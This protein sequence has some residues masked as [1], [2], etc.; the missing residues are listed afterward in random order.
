MTATLTPSPIEGRPV[1]GSEL[2]PNG[3]PA[4]YIIFS[5]QGR[6][7]AYCW[8]IEYAGIGV[9]GNTQRECLETWLEEY[10]D[11]NRKPYTPATR[12]LF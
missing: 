9:T 2:S 4:P 12:T 1:N 11:E 3:Y 6:H 5:T 10:Q 8:E 7:T